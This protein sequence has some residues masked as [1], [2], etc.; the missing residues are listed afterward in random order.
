MRWW[1]AVLV[2]TTLAAQERQP[3]Q[4]VNFYSRE[5]EAALG[6][7]LAADLRK[8]TMSLSS[9]AAH[10]FV[11]Q[12]GL[13][14]A[15][16]L[17][18]GSPTCT[19]EIVTDNPLANELNEPIALPGGYIFVSA[20]LVRT[21]QDEAE[22]AGMLAH[23]M[24]HVAARH[25]TRMA[26]REQLVSQAIPLIYMGGWTYSSTAIPMGFLK[27]LREFELEAD[28]LAVHVMARAG[29]DPAALVRYLEREQHDDDRRPTAFSPLPPRH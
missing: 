27:L 23:A 12:L 22:F 17:P 29:F 8:N 26:T 28:M 18:A 2:A 14:L 24:A 13:R 9:P 19:F 11:A 7:K 21:A 10:D 6:A 3:G 16:Q 4:G 25:A 5:K 20:G 1:M 15:T